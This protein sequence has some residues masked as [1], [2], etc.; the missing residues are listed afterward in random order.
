MN[1]ECTNP[2]ALFWFSYG[3][4]KS[5][6]NVWRISGLNPR[7]NIIK[8]KMYRQKSASAQDGE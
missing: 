5:Q 7:K 2:T 1:V 4:G 8:N 3:F 6:L